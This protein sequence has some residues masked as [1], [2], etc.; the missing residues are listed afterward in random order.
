MKVIGRVKRVRIH[1]TKRNRPMLQDE[2][3]PYEILKHNFRTGEGSSV[4]EVIKGESAAQSLSESLTAKLSQEE[5]EAGWKYF[6]Q[7]TTRKVT[8]H[9]RRV[10]NLKPSSFRKR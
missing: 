2:E 9:P 6:I 8:I 5:R 10:T 7:R 1:L 4:G 3:Y